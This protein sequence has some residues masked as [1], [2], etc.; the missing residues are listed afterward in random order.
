MDNREY[1]TKSCIIEEYLNNFFTYEELAQYLCID[2]DVVKYVL[3][4]YCKLDGTL[5][6]KVSNHRNNIKKYYE[7][8]ND[9]IPYITGDDIK[10]IKIANY[11]IENNASIRNTAKEFGL[12]KTTVHEYIHNKLPDISIKHYKKVFD[13]LMKNKSFSTDS[14]QVINQ[15]LTSYNYLVT[16]Y[17]IAEIAKM[18]NLSW[19]VV[20]RNL[21]GRLMKIDKK[22]YNIA[23]EIFKKHQSEALEENKFKATGNQ[24]K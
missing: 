4:V 5:N 24:K 20:Q 13:V 14:K 23:K 7:T 6:K 12:G 15:V 10:Y 16:G 17:T 11:I 3:D 22:K 19:Y 1:I 18:Q 21:E 2:I 8:L 9:D